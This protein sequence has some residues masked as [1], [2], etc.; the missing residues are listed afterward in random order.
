MNK[1]VENDIVN[2]APISK[3]DISLYCA[4]CETWTKDYGDDLRCNH[5]R[6]LVFTG[7]ADKDF[8]PALD[9]EGKA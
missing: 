2:H 4:E 9:Y 6:Q 5:C 8:Q 3:Q 1:S 7:N